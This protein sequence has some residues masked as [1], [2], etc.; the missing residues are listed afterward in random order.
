MQSIDYNCKSAVKQETKSVD[1]NFKA[2][3]HDLETAVG[4]QKAR[5]ELFHPGPGIYGSRKSSVL[6]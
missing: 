4:H 3:R 5:K 6:T 1:N 2:R